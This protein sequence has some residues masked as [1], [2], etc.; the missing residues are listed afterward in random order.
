ML[1]FGFDGLG[2]HFGPSL[3]FKISWKSIYIYIVF[4]VLPPGAPTLLRKWVQYGREIRRFAEAFYGY[5]IGFEGIFMTW[6]F[7]VGVWF[8]CPFSFPGGAISSAQKKGKCLSAR[9]GRRSRKE[10]V[11]VWLFIA[12]LTWNGRP[13]WLSKST[14]NGEVER[15]WAGWDGRS[16]WRG[17][18]ANLSFSGGSWAVFN[19]KARPVLLYRCVRMY[20]HMYVCK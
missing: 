20:M 1:G 11:V 16:P 8:R 17:S 19:P 18:F 15:P 7:Y 13:N 4:K 5:Y 2:Y 14:C 3:K 10:A 6:R 12:F 9:S